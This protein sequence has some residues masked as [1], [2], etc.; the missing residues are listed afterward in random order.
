VEV[1]E[2]DAGVGGGAARGGVGGDGAD[3]LECVF[4]GEA[5]GIFYEQKDAADLVQG[6]NGA[7]GH[8]GEV[9]RQGGDG[10][11]AEVGGA[12]VELG[13]AGRGQR[14]VDVVPF[15]QSE[16]G[17]LMLEVVEQGSGVQKRDGRDA[18]GHSLIVAVRL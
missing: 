8:D 15:A 16:S 4:C 18:Q 10:D 12:G 6:G 14:V 11:K 9:W 17:R 3:L 2:E 13:G 5:S 1:L 7:P